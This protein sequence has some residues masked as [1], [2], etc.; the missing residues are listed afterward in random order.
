M[1]KQV[2]AEAMSLEVSALAKQAEV[3]FK[4]L[5]ERAAKQTVPQRRQ[6][7]LATLKRLGLVTAGEANMLST[8]LANGDSGAPRDLDKIVSDIDAARNSV[9]SPTTHAILNL[10]RVAAQNGRPSV[11]PASGAK[12]TLKDVEPITSG[13]LI[14][15]AAGATA[16]ATVGAAGTAGFGALPGAI[17][18]AVAG[19]FFGGFV[20]GVG[21]LID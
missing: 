12:L 13:I 9:S 3:V 21:A 1:A 7:S 10:M 5:L 14:G 2:A 11:D 16:G 15:A 4:E 17:G 19:G 20:K 8:I 6:E 18:G